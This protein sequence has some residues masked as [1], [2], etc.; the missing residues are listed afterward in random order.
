MTPSVVKSD[1]DKLH[2]KMNENSGPRRCHVYR[3]DDNINT[4][5][6]HIQCEEY[7]QRG[8]WE[9]SR[10]CQQTDQNHRTSFPLWNTQGQNA[11]T[12]FTHLETDQERERER[13]KQRLLEYEDPDPNQFEMKQ[14]QPR[15][16]ERGP[17]AVG[18][19]AQSARLTA[20]TLVLE[21]QNRGLEKLNLMYVR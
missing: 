4:V 14:R 21:R 15:E 1:K 13:R 6:K 17:M 2:Q 18:D 20:W 5:Y 16:K 19:P 7:D 9:T 11:S 10:R 3:T 12:S 8:C